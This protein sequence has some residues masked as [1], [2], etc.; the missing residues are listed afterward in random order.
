MGKMSAIAPPSTGIRQPRQRC[1]VVKRTYRYL[2]SRPLLRIAHHVSH[3][4]RVARSHGMIAVVH[5]V[6][7]SLVWE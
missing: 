2:T 6:Y 4:G 1:V 3:I 5:V 7:G